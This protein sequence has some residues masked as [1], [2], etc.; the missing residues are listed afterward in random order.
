MSHL[1]SNIVTYNIC[2]LYTHYLDNAMVNITA[3]EWPPPIA[4]VSPNTIQP[5]HNALRAPVC[6][7]SNAHACFTY[8]AIAGTDNTHY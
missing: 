8:T 7:Y 5:A 2:V 6:S 3:C 1:H 4:S